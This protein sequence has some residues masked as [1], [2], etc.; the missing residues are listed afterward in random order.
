MDDD[1]IARFCAATMTGDIDAVI[2][3]FAA[4]AE[5]VSPLA[6]RAVFRGHDDLRVLF[7][8]LL[9]ALTEFSW[10]RLV[11]GDDGTAVAVAEARVLGVRIGDAMMIEQDTNGR[12][13]RITPH[14]RPWLGSTLLAAVL[15]PKLVRHPAMIRR[16]FGHDRP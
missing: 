12:I 11:R 15:G 1:A 14:V 5:L 6:G 3:T 10:F 13:R 4:D 16:A 8:I 9:P 7:S 2:E